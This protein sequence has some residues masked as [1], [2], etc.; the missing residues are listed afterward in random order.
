VTVPRY[1]QCAELYSTYVPFVLV[2][3]HR[4]DLLLDEEKIET[5]VEKVEN[6][7]GKE[8]EVTRTY[9]RREREQSRRDEKR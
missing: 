8:R 1:V 6:R 3:Y 9:R 4:R 2:S 7:R 5:D